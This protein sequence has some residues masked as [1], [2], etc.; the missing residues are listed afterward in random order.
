MAAVIR[1]L[2]VVNGGIFDAAL[3]LGREEAQPN[4]IGNVLVL[5]KPRELFQEGRVLVGTVFATAGLDL[6]RSVRLG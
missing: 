6:G 1:H 4:D 3:L 2:V 5:H